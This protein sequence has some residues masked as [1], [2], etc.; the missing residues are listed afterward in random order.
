[1]EFCYGHQVFKQPKE[2]KTQTQDLLEFKVLRK[3]NNIITV[4]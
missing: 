2:E 1:V 4:L 3:L